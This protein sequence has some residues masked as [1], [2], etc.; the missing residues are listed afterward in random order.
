MD[1]WFREIHVPQV[2][3]V[4]LATGLDFRE[5]NR[6]CFG[7]IGT[8]LWLESPTLPLYYEGKVKNTIFPQN[9][10]Y[11]LDKNNSLHGKFHR[12][13]FPFSSNFSDLNFASYVLYIYLCYVT[14]HTQ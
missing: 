5:K 12:F 2:W 7:S 1:S 6:A 4:Y 8:Q 3:R 14:C 9:F 11:V 13:L 10:V